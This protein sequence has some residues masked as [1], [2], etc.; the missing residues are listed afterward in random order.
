MNSTSHYQENRSTES[1]L[2]P[3]LPP[4]SQPILSCW[5]PSSGFRIGPSGKM[6]NQRAG[7]RAAGCPRLSWAAPP[8][9]AG[10]E[11]QEMCFHGGMMAAFVLRQLLH[12]L[13]SRHAVLS[14]RTSIWLMKSPP[15]GRWIPILFGQHECVDA[16][17]YNKRCSTQSYHRWS[18]SD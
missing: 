8:S 13:E 9:M 3:V 7:L 17:T 4:V 12:Y 15:A 1:G 6:H 14:T 18:L 10:S 16:A 2:L 5:Q 11:N